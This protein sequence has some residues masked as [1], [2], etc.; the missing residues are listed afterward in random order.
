MNLSPKNVLIIEAIPVERAGQSEI[1]LGK[2]P[3]LAYPEK[4]S[5]KLREKIEEIA[6]Q[7][8]IPL[9]DFPGFESRL[10]S[11]FSSGETD[12]LTLGL[13]VKFSSTPVEVLDLK[14]ILA[15]E[16]LL[17]GLLE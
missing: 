6:K 1:S 5:S 8:G 14:D 9:Q 11:P 2:G 7:N 12:A 4:S 16:K 13:P 15:L 17:S 3:I 10:M